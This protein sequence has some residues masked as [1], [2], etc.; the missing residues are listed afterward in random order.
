MTVFFN[1]LTQAFGR[2]FKLFSG[3]NERNAGFLR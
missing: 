2:Y 1:A 3:F